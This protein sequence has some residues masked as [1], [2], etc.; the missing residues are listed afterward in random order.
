MI[1]DGDKMLLEQFTGMIPNKKLEKFQKIVD[2]AYGDQ[3]QTSA[4]YM[5]EQAKE[6]LEGT[7][8]KLLMLMLQMRG[9]FDRT[10]GPM[11]SKSSQT[12]GILIFQD[13]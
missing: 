12:E 3:S 8:L 10:G 11:Q 5:L 6:H 9:Q 7:E 1:A 2:K 4:H 13:Q